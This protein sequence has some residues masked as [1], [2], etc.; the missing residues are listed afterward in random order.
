MKKCKGVIAAGDLLTA[1]AGAE[2]LHAGGNAFDAAI[3]ATFMSFAASSAITSAAGGGF[4]LA[5]QAGSDSLM[6][7]FFVH[8]PLAKRS[9]DELDFE[10]VEIDF[11]DKCQE[12][13]IGLGTLAT[14]GNIA[15]LFAVHRDLGSLPMSEIMAPT[16]ERI[17]A[18]ITLHRQ[19]KYQIDI[20]RPILNKNTTGK[21]IY[22]PGL[23]IGDKY[24][25]AGM[26][27]FFDFLARSGPREFYEGEIAHYIA[28]MCAEQGGQLT[29]DDFRNY[30]VIKR[31]PLET[32][33]RQAR[34]FTN[35]PPNAGGPLIA[36]LLTL[37]GS[38]ALRPGDFGKTRHL[39]ALLEAIKRTDQTRSDRLVAGNLS[40]HEIYLF[41]ENF[42][43][44]IRTSY[45]KALHKSGNT[46]HVSVID[47]LGNVAVCTTSVGEGCGHF[48]PGT[49][50]MLNNML[51]EQDL[52]PQGFQY[53]NPDRR[54]SSMMSP[55]VVLKANNEL[56]G[57]GSG[58]SNRIRSAIAQ[59]IINYIDFRLPPD[60]IVNMPRIHLENDH[61]DI[62]PGFRQEEIDKL[63]LPDGVEKFYWKNQ[64]M[65]FGGVH[66]VFMDERKG[67]SGAADRR[68]AG[69]VIAV[70]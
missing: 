37:F 1:E 16:L 54:L 30:K 47:A 50:T 32:T 67:L 21:H 31:K 59:A 29:Y 12:F 60:D 22:T 46:T 26:L 69:E 45:I 63:L 39:Q 24:H 40:D 33:Y 53:W 17:R 7:D 43:N 13:H 41:D 28:K 49:D 10:A 61:L 20:L 44:S 68:R 15:G 38:A 34:L 48:M 64:N 36:L 66:A 56:M 11:G 58:G 70:Y 51:G 35:P 9:V 62:E 19:T 2:I 52:N 14:P 18:G 8:T 3:A 23:D 55:T 42:L 6:Y 4:L 57:L 25:L 27:D 65:Y 5:H